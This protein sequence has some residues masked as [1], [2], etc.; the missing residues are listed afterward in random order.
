M[1]ATTKT[2]AE[3]ELRPENSEI[4]ELNE[5]ELDHVCG[6]GFWSSFTETLRCGWYGVVDGVK[7]A[8]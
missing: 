1:S 4:G 7:K 2:N 3:L 8:L 6:G 5:N